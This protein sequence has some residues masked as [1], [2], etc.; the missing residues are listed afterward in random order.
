M[1]TIRRLLTRLFDIREGEYLRTLLMFSYLLLIIGCY[2]TTKSVRDA[3]FLKKLGAEQ[4]PFVYILIA[5]V[6][7]VVSSI[8]SRAALGTPVVRLIRFTSLISVAGFVGFRWLLEYDWPWMFYVLYIWVSVFGAVTASQFWLL[9]NFVF[10]PREAKRLFAFIGAGGVLGGILG[11]VFTQYGAGWFGTSNL[12]LWCGGFMGLS[13]LCLERVWRTSAWPPSDYQGKPEEQARGGETGRMLGLIM[14]SRHLTMIAVILTVAVIVESFVDYQLKFISNDIFDNQDE[15][16][17]FLGALFAYVSIFSLLFQMFLTGRILK[18]FGVGVSILFQP[19]GLLLGSSILAFQPSLLAVGFLKIS[20]GSFRYSIHRSGIELLFLPVP[21]A[22][23][24]QVKGFIDMFIDRLGRGLGGV[25]LWLLTGVLAF[26]VTGLSVMASA[27]IIVWLG[28]SI[29][30]KREYLNA[31]RLALEKKTIEP[32]QLRISISD[33]ASIAA[34][35]KVLNSAEERQVIYA[36]DLLEDVTPELWLEHVKP[37]L[38]HPSAKVRALALEKLSGHGD[39]ELTQ[40]VG[41]LLQDSDLQV[42]IEAIHYLC[43]ASD[44]APPEQLKGFLRERDYSIVSAA[45]GCLS[46][47]RW[48]SELLIDEE[49]F[50]TALGERG[51]H[52][53]TARIAAAAAL[54]LLDASSPLQ[55]HLGGLLE[56]ESHE[57]VKNAMHSAGRNQM[58]EAVPRIIRKLENRHLRAEARDALLKFGTRIVGTLRDYL[59]DPSESMVVRAA[60]PKILSQIRSQEAVDA[61]TS[62]VDLADQFLGYR[63]LKALNKMRS[64]FPELKFDDQVVDSLILEELKDYYR[65]AFILRFKD[66]EDQIQQP[67]VQLLVKALQ[68]RMDQKLERVFRLLGLRYPP[69]DIYSAYNGLRS[70]KSHQRAS[71][72]E[73]LDNLLVPKLKQLLFPILEES[74]FEVMAQNGSQYFGLQMTPRHDHLEQL[75]AGKDPWLKTISVYAAGCFQLSELAGPVQRSMQ[76]PDPFVRETAAWSWRRLQVESRA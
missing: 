21:M 51:P 50:A 18:R 19:L 72:I 27:L 24:A 26:E 28:L 47:Y 22:V 41:R 60:I 11:G 73:F 52:R 13:V 1:L 30:I 38:S 37:L 3:L 74:S 75:I 2:I 56:D 40:P 66:R 61:L 48:E 6:V 67:V 65:F 68:E 39:R 43:L 17:S 36:M 57:V 29:V 71:A 76:D 7:G 69:A 55:R 32:E 12:L 9:A 25:L 23:K 4:L 63:V 10:N 58:R 15:L 34:L 53:E 70:R 20:D 64:S 35:V 62:S 8:Y 16:T 45:I 49:F 59:N 31:F 33:S 14:K 42:R 44:I 54:G 5:V 46:K